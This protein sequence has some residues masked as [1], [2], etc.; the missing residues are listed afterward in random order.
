K[1]DFMNP[2]AESLTSWT[3]SEAK[4]RLIREVFPI[5]NESTRTP[6][7]NPVDQVIQSG[8]GAELANHTVLFAKDGSEIFIDD[9]AAPIR[10][11]DGKIFGVVLVFRDISEKKRAERAQLQ[12]AA[13]VESSNDGF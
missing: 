6:V 8:Q 11:N 2:A 12:L 10:G 7:E 1:I 4:G 5:I 3:N 9:S 13:I